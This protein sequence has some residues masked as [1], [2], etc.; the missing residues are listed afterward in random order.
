VP[1]GVSET[2]CIGFSPC[3]FNGSFIELFCVL[4]SELIACGNPFSDALPCFLEA[5]D[6]EVDQLC[7]G[8][9]R[10]KAAACFGGFADDA[11]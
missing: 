7:R 5:A 3:V 11:I 9:V 8:L 2:L 1:Q 4:D 10:W 6:G